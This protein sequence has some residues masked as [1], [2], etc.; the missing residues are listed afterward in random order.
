MKKPKIKNTVDTEQVLA[1]LGDDDTLE[2]AIEI[3]ADIA[4]GDYKPNLLRQEITDY[5]QE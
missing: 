5:N 3:I 1:W 2:Q 4:N